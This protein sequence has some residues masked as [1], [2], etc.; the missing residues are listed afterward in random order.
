MAQLQHRNGVNTITH[1]DTAATVLECDAAHQA[2]YDFS[3]LHDSTDAANAVDLMHANFYVFGNAA[4]LGVSNAVPYY[5]F[6]K[7]DRFLHCCHD[8]VK[9]WFQNV[10]GSTAYITVYFLRQ[11]YPDA[12]DP[13]TLLYTGENVDK[14]FDRNLGTMWPYDNTLLGSQTPIERFNINNCGYLWQ[15][16]KLIDT[17]SITIKGG[18]H[19][20]KTYSLK[21][22]NIKPWW[23]EQT[24]SNPGRVVLLMR[25]RGELLSSATNHV[26]YSK[27]EVNLDYQVIQ[28]YKK[29]KMNSVPMEVWANSD[30]IL[31]DAATEK[32]TGPPK[33]VYTHSEL[34]TALGSDQLYAKVS[35]TGHWQ[36]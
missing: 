6:A 13:D 26:G 24:V 18:R 14:L 7:Q 36:T 5:N 28:T 29:P 31:A 21:P 33:P 19:A 35:A 4:G 1:V 34:V 32:F 25:V 3:S 17:D 10:L 30:S 16:Y 2:W 9:F 8:S 27:V 22:Y 20:I 11:R 15:Y 23:A 12:P